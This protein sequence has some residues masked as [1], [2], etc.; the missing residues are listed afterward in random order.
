MI[1]EY[2]LDLDVKSN[3]K[4][5]IH[6]LDKNKHNPHF[7]HLYECT[8]PILILKEA[9]YSLLSEFSKLYH[10]WELGVRTDPKYE[11][12]HPLVLEE[13]KTLRLGKEE[14]PEFNSLNNLVERIFS[15]NGNLKKIRNIPSM[16]ADVVYDLRSYVFA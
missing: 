6:D 13:H 7:D 1:Q 16:L 5:F 10:H 8:V 15:V 3:I 9:G 2:I 4:R 14:R 12:L 11:D